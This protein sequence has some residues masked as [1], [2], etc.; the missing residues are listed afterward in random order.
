MWRRAGKGQYL[1]KYLIVLISF[2]REPNTVGQSVRRSL[3]AMLSPQPA[4]SR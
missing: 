4:E 3:G 2:P 1:F